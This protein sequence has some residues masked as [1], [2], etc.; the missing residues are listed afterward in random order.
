MLTEMLA[1]FLTHEGAPQVLIKCVS[2]TV[3]SSKV[4]E[5]VNVPTRSSSVESTGP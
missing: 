3:M 2:N 1:Q 5:P 4:T